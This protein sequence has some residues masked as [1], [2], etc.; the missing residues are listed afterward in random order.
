MATP[1]AP[2][3]ILC[4]LYPVPLDVRPGITA[5][6]VLSYRSSALPSSYNI[7]CIH[8][9]RLKAGTIDGIVNWLLDVRFEGD[10]RVIRAFLLC[11]R[12]FMQPKELWDKVR[13]ICAASCLTQPR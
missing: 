10:A 9:H 3:R 5:T 13:I 4:Y 8:R 2:T 12:L 7:P 11:Y 1:S 6:K